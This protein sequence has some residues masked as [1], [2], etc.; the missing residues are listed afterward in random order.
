MKKILIL[1]ALVATL[2]SVNAMA[3]DANI[4]F[5]GTVS[6]STCTLA[7]ADA[8]K[9]LTI[10]SVAAATLYATANNGYLTYNASSSFGFSACPA[11]LTK[12]ISNYTYQGSLNGSSTDTA[13]AT[14]T[15]TNV[16]LIVMQNST[17]TNATIVKANGTSSTANQTT[18]VSNAATVPVTVGVQPYNSSG[19]VTLPTVGTYTGTYTVAFTYS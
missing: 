3:A 17:A 15:A 1:S 8:S 7:A 13:T 11:G 18:I 2:A 16:A 19:T 14:G 4:T 12:V 6:A 5:N 9:V 10:P